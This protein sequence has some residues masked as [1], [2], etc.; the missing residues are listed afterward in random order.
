MKFGM[1]MI[2]SANSKVLSEF[3]ERILGKPD[4]DENGWYVWKSGGVYF[5]IGDHSE[6]KGKSKEPQRLILNFESRTYRKEY[7]RVKSLGAKVVKELY[8]IEGQWIATFADPDGNYFQII[9][10]P[11]M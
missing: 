9:S 10:P 8:E 11:K 7:E 1:I 2:G 6:V 3:Y 5:G 4:F